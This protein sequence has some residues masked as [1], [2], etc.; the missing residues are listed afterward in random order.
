MHCLISMTGYDDKV[1][2]KAIPPQRALISL[3]ERLVM[4]AGR[5]T[6]FDLLIEALAADASFDSFT[7]V[8]GAFLT[9]SEKGLSHA[10][11]VI[12]AGAVQVTRLHAHF[13]DM[14]DHR[15]DI[16]MEDKVDSFGH[17]NS[18]LLDGE[19]RIQL[20]YR[21]LVRAPD[22]NRVA[23]SQP[24]PLFESRHGRNLNGGL[25]ADQMFGGSLLSGAFSALLRGVGEIPRSR[26]TVDHAILAGILA[27]EAGFP[28]TISDS[29]RPSAQFAAAAAREAYETFQAEGYVVSERGWNPKLFLPGPRLEDAVSAADDTARGFGEGVAQPLSQL[30]PLSAHRVTHALLAQMKEDPVQFS[31]RD[32]PHQEASAHA[33]LEIQAELDTLLRCSRALPVPA[34]QENT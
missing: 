3:D 6:P 23:P 28:V 25:R 18:L 4:I 8:L 32:H 20:G 24:A 22:R 14:G 2:H 30:D 19:T 11:A 9:L 27:S 13:P 21:D 17:A 33:R 29:H 34:Q 12:P 15:I 7:D 26:F 31:L 5:D 1:N 16:E 10:H